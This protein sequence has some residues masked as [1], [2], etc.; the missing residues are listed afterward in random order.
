MHL[1]PELEGV[2]WFG[3]TTGRHWPRWQRGGAACG[4]GGSATRG[5]GAA[6]GSAPGPWRPGEAVA[7]VPTLGGG[8]A[9][10]AVRRRDSGAARGSA[11]GGGGGGG[12]GGCRG[13]GVATPGQRCG[14]GTA[15]RRGGQ[16]AGGP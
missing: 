6:G 3:A 1:L 9:G 12:G 14:A 15:V 13:G 10:T 4:V 7:G 8:D 11:G 2:A 16:R 5:A